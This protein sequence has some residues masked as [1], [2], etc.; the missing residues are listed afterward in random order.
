MRARRVA[1]RIHRRDFLAAVAGTTAAAAL[2]PVAGCALVDPAGGPKWRMKLSTSTV[3]FSSLSI[4]DACRRI[5]ALGFTGVDIWCA[6]QGCPHLDD[7][8]DRLGPDGLSALL[9][10]T[11]LELNSFSTYVG[12]FAKYAELLG[13]V[14]GGVAVQGS[15]GPCEPPEL[16][17]R[18]RQFLEDLKPLAELAEETNSYLAIENHGHALLD[19]LDSL[20][21]FV[22]LNE[23]PRVGIALA[24]YHLQAIEASI[25]EAIEIC[26]EQ[27]LFFYA[28][29][30]AP[31]A[32]QLPG[33]GPVDCVPWIEA[34]AR[35][36][37]RGHV[38]PFMHGHPEPDAMAAALAESKAYLSEC[39]AETCG[40]NVS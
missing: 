31:G 23:S 32:E 6:Y 33:L 40:G 12:G 13:G 10:E 15:A 5:A 3:Q 38:N 24:P 2:A 16:A 20:E 4:E 30:N 26:G 22:D 7:C 11:K 21:A 8:L 39:H 19:S 1:R 37:Y 28:W 17:S 27:L 9:E 25:P 36:D 18:M 29:Q 34:L 14:G 35:I